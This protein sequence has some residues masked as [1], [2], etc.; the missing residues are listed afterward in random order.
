MYGLSLRG[1]QGGLPADGPE[2]GGYLFTS[3]G[4]LGAGTWSWKSGGKYPPFARW[5]SAFAL[6]AS[7]FALRASAFALRASVDKSV[8]KSG[9]EPRYW[10]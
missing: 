3:V 5:A 6:R 8:D 9:G 1:G 7:T 10:F 4:F 2:A